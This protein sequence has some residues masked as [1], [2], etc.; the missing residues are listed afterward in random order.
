MPYTR[1]NDQFITNHISNN[2]GRVCSPSD[3][4]LVKTLNGGKK[5]KKYSMRYKKNKSKRRKRYTRRYTGG[6]KRK[7]RVSR[8][9]ISGRKR[10]RRLTHKSNRKKKRLRR[11]KMSGGSKAIFFNHIKTPSFGYKN[12]NV[13]ANE[14]ASL[15]NTRPYMS[16]NTPVGKMCN[17]AGGKRRKTLRRNKYNKKQHGGGLFTT[18]V[19]LSLPAI[20]GAGALAYHKQDWI[21]GLFKNDKDTAPR[22]ISEDEK[23]DELAKSGYLDALTTNPFA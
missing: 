16:E 19:G 10:K 3:A 2:V 8:R 14:N 17:M 4:Y 21:K 7:R 6:R 1:L 15:G 5:K 9:Y 18:A 23:Q 20:L 12:H 13:A 11:S 22:D